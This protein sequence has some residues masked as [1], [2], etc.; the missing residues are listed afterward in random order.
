[1]NL[2]KNNTFIYKNEGSSR[3]RFYTYWSML[4]NRQEIYENLY[5]APEDMIC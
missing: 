5:S 2:E 3:T 1:M 4:L